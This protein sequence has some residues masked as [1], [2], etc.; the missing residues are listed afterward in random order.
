MC[1]CTDYFQSF[2]L[3]IF[4]L[5]LQHSIQ[6]RCVVCTQCFLTFFYK[7]GILCGCVGVYP[8]YGRLDDVLFSSLSL[9][10]AAAAILSTRQINPLSAKTNE[11][12]PCQLSIYLSLSLSLSLSSVSVLWYNSWWWL[13]Y[14]QI[15]LSFKSQQRHRERDSPIQFRRDIWDW[16]ATSF[17]PIYT[18]HRN[19]S[20]LSL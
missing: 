19:A 18:I 7:G 12:L 3:S 6:I 14:V 11:E 20:T 4:K 13:L 8:A 10:S 9:L 15:L 16:V 2:T 5:F 17:F 1:V